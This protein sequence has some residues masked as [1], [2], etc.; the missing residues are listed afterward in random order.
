MK[1]KRRS[2]PTRG[3]TILS[4]MLCLRQT[5]TISEYLEQFEELSAEVPHVPHDVLEEI[6]L[7]RMN[8]SLREQVVRLRPIGMYEIVDMA[9]IIEEQENECSPYQS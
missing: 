8:R 9:K 7:H 2:K 3:G 6:F 5:G 1:L 4:Q